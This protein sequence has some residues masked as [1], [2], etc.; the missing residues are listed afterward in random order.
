M[1][2]CT[3]N[4]NLCVLILQM[5]EMNDAAE[6]EEN[7]NLSA[8]SILFLQNIGLLSG[9]GLMLLM[10]AYGGHIEEAIKGGS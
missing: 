6:V 5:P 10:A 4:M 3:I 8:Y 9:F 7:Q 1:E 2:K